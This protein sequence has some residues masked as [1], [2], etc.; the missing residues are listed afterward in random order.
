MG[1]KTTWNV[2]AVLGGTSTLT[3][4]Q[5]SVPWAFSLPDGSYTNTRFL[6]RGQSAV[7]GWPLLCEQLGQGEFLLL[8]LG[9]HDL[10]LAALA[11]E[12][13]PSYVRGFPRLEQV[14]VDLAA[15]LSGHRI[16]LRPGVCLFQA[17]SLEQ[18]TALFP[19]LSAQAAKLKFRSRLVD[20]LEANLS[21]H[22]A[23]C[24]AAL[25]ESV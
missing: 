3:Q 2:H 18:E 10:G 12:L 24:C 8:H 13:D 25:T 20:P 23:L 14:M 7:A 1:V 16:A 5:R 22:A 11:D 19:K 6:S 4:A 21:R 15:S 17:E 9:A